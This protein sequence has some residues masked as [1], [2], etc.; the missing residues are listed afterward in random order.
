MAKASSKVEAD[1]QAAARKRA[2]A[3]EIARVTHASAAAAVQADK[4]ALQ[5]ERAAMENLQDFADTIEL[6]VGGTRFKTSRATLVRCRGSFLESM[7]S[8]RHKIDACAD[9]SYFIDRDPT[10]FRIV[11]NFLRTG[12]AITPE[13]PVARAE[14]A[15]EADFYIL[16]TLHRALTA[17]APDLTVLLG[18]E[19]FSTCDRRDDETTYS[20]AGLRNALVIGP[21]SGLVSLFEGGVDAAASALFY[22]PEPCGFPILLKALAAERTQ[23]AAP[24]HAQPPGA[25]PAD[26]QA[27]H[28]R[29]QRAARAHA[30]LHS[31]WGGACPLIKN[32][33]CA[34]AA[35]KCL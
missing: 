8:G 2:E 35:P 25:R 33:P 26:G 13:D 17:P 15:A 28:R 30:R 27:T 11:L 29:R 6:D 1:I 10:H 22:E 4:Q 7:F 3:D 34:I 20:R 18:P 16:P 14:A 31:W 12:V 21:H 19:T 9:G 23:Q 24:E 32:F 5:A